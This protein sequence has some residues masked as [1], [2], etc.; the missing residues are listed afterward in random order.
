MPQGINFMRQNLAGIML[1]TTIAALLYGTAS[2]I[3]SKD[4]LLLIISLLLVV[5]ALV[6]SFEAG[7]VL[8]KLY[9]KRI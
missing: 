1:L 6:L 3:R 2:Y 5:S 9:K 8:K 4:F 7:K